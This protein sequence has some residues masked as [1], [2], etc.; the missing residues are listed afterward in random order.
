MDKAESIVMINRKPAIGK[1]FSMERVFSVVA[2]AMPNDVSILQYQLPSNGV[3]V[4]SIRNNIVAA[5]SVQAD[6]V[7]VTGD[8]HY[9]LP[10]VS[11]KSYRV[12]T[13]HDI[14]SLKRLT[15]MRR[16]CVRSWWYSFPLAAA[17]VVT[18]VSDKTRLDLIAEFPQHAEKI[19]VVENPITVE[20]TRCDSSEIKNIPRILAI[21]TGAN[22]NLPRLVQAVSDLEVELRVIGPAT[23]ALST[24]IDN[25]GSAN[26]TRAQNLSNEEMAREYRSATLL[27][28][29]S[30]SE[31]FGLPIIEAQAYG[32]PV[33]TSDLEPMR[34]VAGNAAVLCD[35][36][37]HQAI[38]SSI[39][40]VLDDERLRK[41][42]VENG[43][44]SVVR[45]FPKS[46]A[47]DYLTIYRSGRKPKGE[48]C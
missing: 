35:P 23:T 43:F 3:S 8:V 37:D 48:I 22:K 19:H 15:G 39:C 31:G 28:F 47:N 24:A 41:K 4:R 26:V 12:L 9:V 6:V 10:F 2:N 40:T 44:K 25:H 21:G 7:H 29:M 11:Q 34:S 36:F 13:V 46:I 16:L 5:R 27:A 17:D 30:T 1:H 38:R 18:T 42:N 45:Y 33:V 20:P 32:V 14:E